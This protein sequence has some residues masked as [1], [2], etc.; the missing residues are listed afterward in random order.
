MDRALLLPMMLF[1]LV[2]MAATDDVAT[3]HVTFEGAEK[4][5]PFS[6]SNLP[7]LV[8]PDSLVS[9]WSV[10][11]MNSLAGAAVTGALYLLRAIVQSSRQ[12]TATICLRAAWPGQLHAMG[13]L[14]R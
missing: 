8:V 1:V 2:H 3:V 7:F 14:V 5:L 11:L 6:P 9:L 10:W 12:S 13:Q 4:V